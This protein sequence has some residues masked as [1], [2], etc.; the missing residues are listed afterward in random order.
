M[1]RMVGR[2]DK[3][4]EEGAIGGVSFRGGKRRAVGNLH[5]GEG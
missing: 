5:V 2:G 3:E 4:K 1:L